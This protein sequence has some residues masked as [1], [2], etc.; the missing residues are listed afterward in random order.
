VF[1]AL[2]S[3]YQ[4]LPP[5]WRTELKKALTAQGHGQSRLDWF[6]ARK[7]ATGKKRLDR[8]LEGLLSTLGVETAKQLGGKVCVDFGAGY[9]PTDGV[10][11]W[12][13]GASEVHG[14]D[15]NA[16]ARPSEIAK[17]VRVADVGSVEAQLKVLGIDS[18][19]FDRWSTLRSW[20][21]RDRGDFPPGYTYI[22]PAD[23]IASPSLLPH[24][25]VLVSTSVLEHI[26]PSLMIALLD[27]IK[28]RENDRA[29]QA[30]RVD[31]RDHRDFDNNPYGF[32][33]PS[34]SFDAESDADSRGN[35]MTMWD[36][37]S[38]V[39]DHPE[40]ALA[41]GDHQLGRPHLL[42]S[43]VANAHRRVIADSLVLRSITAEQCER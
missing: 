7:D 19:W 33:D 21:R 18:A 38:L 14:V 40:W 17:A 11:L 36:W 16:I 2:H 22:A 6:T 5:P 8:A 26:R 34:D 20:A 42:P 35:G 27:A 32:L 10:A 28:S 15:Y 43:A 37:G 41:I 3:L 29:V 12:L 31:L 1:G 13:L 9:V 23:V 4:K 25:D 39:S 30:H 24:F